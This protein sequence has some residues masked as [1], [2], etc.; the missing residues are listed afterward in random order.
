MAL[1]DRDYIL[2]HRF[3]SGAMRTILGHVNSGLSN[4]ITERELE[5]NPELLKVMNSLLQKGARDL[6]NDEEVVRRCIDYKKLEEAR[7]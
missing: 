1:L 5:D 3:E 4:R 6:F 2:Y 7:K